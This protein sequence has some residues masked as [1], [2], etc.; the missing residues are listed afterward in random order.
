MAKLRGNFRFHLL[1]QGT[2]G[3]V[4]RNLARDA[5]TGLS[6]PEDVLWFADVDPLDM[7]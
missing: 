4:L 2:N 6:R 7:L 5:D 3:E 1:L